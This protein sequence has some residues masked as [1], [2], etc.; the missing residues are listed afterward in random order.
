[1]TESSN[2]TICSCKSEDHKLNVLT[3]CMLDNPFSGIVSSK[4]EVCLAG[5]NE[6]EHVKHKHVVLEEAER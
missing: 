2:K 3:S 6:G 4:D 5:N 1:M